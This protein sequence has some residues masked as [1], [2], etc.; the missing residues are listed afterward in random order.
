MID[1]LKAALLPL[2]DALKLPR[3]PYIIVAGGKRRDVV[4]Q[5]KYVDRGAS[6]V[7]K[8]LI[9]LE[10][11]MDTKLPKADQFKSNFITFKASIPDLAKYGGMSVC[12]MNEEP[13][14][15]NGV[16]IP[17]WCHWYIPMASNG[18]FVGYVGYPDARLFILIGHT[19]DGYYAKKIA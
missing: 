11:A 13:V 12:L 2:V 18:D 14:T 6:T 5:A 9:K 8:D 4:T 3:V 1:K 16:V 15:I 7:D 17:S 10:N 19:R